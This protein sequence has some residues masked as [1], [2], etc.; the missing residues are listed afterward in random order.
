MLE[1]EAKSVAAAST[2]V[3]ALLIARSPVKRRIAHACCVRCA[4]YVT[5]LNSKILIAL[6]WLLIRRRSTGYL[7]P[8]AGINSQHKA[9]RIFEFKGVTYEAHRTQQA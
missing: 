1:E 9:I 5:P 2:A 4:S 3:R 8:P 7:K 6:C